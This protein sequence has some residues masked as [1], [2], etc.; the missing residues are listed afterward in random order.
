M[1]VSAPATSKCRSRPTS[2]ALDQQP[3]REQ[4]GD[5]ADRHVDEQHPLPAGPLGQHA[6]E[7][8]AGRAAGARDRAPDAQRG[9]ALGALLEGGGDDRQR[10]GRDQRGAEA[11][12][13]AGDDQPQLAL[14]E[15]AGQRGDREEDEARDEHAPPA[16]QVGQAA[17]EQQEAAEDQG[18]GVDDP[19]QVVLGEV[20]VLADRR[21]RD[22]DDRRVEDD[23]ELGGREKGERQPL[24]GGGVG[25]RQGGANLRGLWTVTWGRCSDN[26]ENRFRLSSRRATVRTGGLHGAP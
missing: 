22:V 17:A 25:G 14:G 1:T 4:R 20:E 10:G 15:A 9:V 2:R 23:D 24:V 12:H 5:D 7:Q 19:G 26:T 3:R 13:G 16:E 8:H 11:L 6:A 21:Q 18:V